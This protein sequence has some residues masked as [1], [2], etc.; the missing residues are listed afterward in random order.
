MSIN[1]A[2]TIAALEVL[3]EQIKDAIERAAEEVRK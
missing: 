3:L 2:R 1:E